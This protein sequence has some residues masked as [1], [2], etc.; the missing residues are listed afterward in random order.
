MT[1]EEWYDG[2]MYWHDEDEVDQEYLVRIA[3]AAWDAANKTNVWKRALDN[4]LVL[5][6]KLTPEEATFKE[7]MDTLR[8]LLLITQ[9]L[10]TDP[11]VNGGYVLVP[12]EP[13]EAMI[14]AG[15]LECNDPIPVVTDV[16]NAMIKAAQE[17][18]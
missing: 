13:T 18:E 6:G 14:N 15:W 3:Q 17:E 2:Y 4:E 12:V 9:S 16:Y 1:F 7:A 11:L 10:A 8:T 5:W